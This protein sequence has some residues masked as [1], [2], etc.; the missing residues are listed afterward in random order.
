MTVALFTR[1]GLW[2]PGTV[3]QRQQAILKGAIL[4]GFLIACIGVG[5]GMDA[6]PPVPGRRG[7]DPYN[8]TVH[9][10]VVHAGPVEGEIVVV[11]TSIA[12]V[13]FNASTSMLSFVIGDPVHG[14]AL[15]VE[16]ENHAP[17]VGLVDGRLLAIKA[18]SRLIA[19][20]RLVGVDYVV[21]ETGT[22]LVASIAG[23]AVLVI[24]VLGWFTIDWRRLVLVPRSRGR[25]GREGG[26]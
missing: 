22:V 2:D 16:F 20:D 24:A 17:P 12:N 11:T 8:M 1:A 23:A 15:R 14:H 18:E 4:A 21:L 19:E 25:D 7:N 9:Q 3:K 26:T 10:L 6:S 5:A 13:S